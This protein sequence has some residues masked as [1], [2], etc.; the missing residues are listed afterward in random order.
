MQWCCT[1]AEQGCKAKFYT[2]PDACWYW[3]HN[4]H[5]TCVEPPQDDL[6]QEELE[7]VK[8]DVA[9]MLLGEVMPAPFPTTKAI[10]KEANTPTGYN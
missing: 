9:E 4:P 6:T 8:Q 2:T 5:H 1:K 10:S 3:K 7:E